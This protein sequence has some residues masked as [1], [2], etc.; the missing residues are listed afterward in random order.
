MKQIPDH[1]FSR[2]EN[3]G[4]WCNPTKKR[5][6]NLSNDSLYDALV[7]LFEKYSLNFDKFFIAASSQSNGSFNNIVANKAHKNKCSSTTAICDIRVAAAACAE[8]DSEK[9]ILNVQ[10]KLGF[11]S[12][13]QTVKYV[14]Q[15]VI[16]RVK[17]SIANRSKV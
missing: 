15:S 14:R 2:H 9:S 5:T 13:S 1:I 8:N 3:C 4:S 12:A 7:S 10:N 17:K 6:L 16:K 11:P